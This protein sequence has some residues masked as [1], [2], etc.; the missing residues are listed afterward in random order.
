[1]LITDLIATWCCSFTGQE[2]VVMS[3]ERPVTFFVYF[4]FV[5][6]ILNSAFNSVG[7]GLQLFYCIFIEGGS[8]SSGKLL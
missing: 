2:L 6:L 4:F 5:N 7:Y 3:S 8:Y 1:M